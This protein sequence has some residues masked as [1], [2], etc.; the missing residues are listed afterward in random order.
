MTFQAIDTQYIIDT[1]IGAASRA[2]LEMSLVRGHKGVIQGFYGESLLLPDQS[3]VKPMLFLRNVND[4]GHA[5]MI[6]VG[7]YRMVCSNGL[8]FGDDFFSRRIIHREGITLSNFLLN[9]DADLTDAFQIAAEFY[10]DK[11]KE[12][13]SIGVAE[14]QG[15]QI[16]GSLNLPN[17]VKDNA[18]FNWTNPSRDEDSSRTLWTLYNVVNEANR[19]RSNSTNSFDRELGLLTHMEALYT[20]EMKKVA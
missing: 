11:V 17:N 6:G 1:A 16:V 10:A 9:L 19:K 14:N 18:I 2:G 4:G 8:T 12:L 15:I 3:V 7:L 20:H 13:I 5:L